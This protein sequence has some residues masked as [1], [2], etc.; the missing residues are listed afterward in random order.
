ME[1][2]RTR[3]PRWTCTNCSR[4]LWRVACGACSQALLMR[5]SA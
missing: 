5:L 1:V 4:G 3:R 2:S